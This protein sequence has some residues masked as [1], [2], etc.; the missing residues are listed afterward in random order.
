MPDVTG[1]FPLFFGRLREHQVNRGAYIEN[2]PGKQVSNVYLAKPSNIVSRSTDETAL[3]TSLPSY[4][5]TAHEG[6]TSGPSPRGVSSWSANQECTEPRLQ[7]NSPITLSLSREYSPQRNRSSTWHNVDSPR[8]SRPP[9]PTSEIP[10]F[11]P[12]SA[13]RSSPNSVPRPSRG[14]TVVSIN[15]IV[16]QAGNSPC[17]QHEV[18]VVT[19]A[20]ARWHPGNVSKQFAM[21]NKLCYQCIKSFVP[22]PIG[23]DPRVNKR[24]S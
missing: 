2:R 12:S 20:R 9:R 16:G 13:T 4:S 24:P 18:F 11:D 3:Q 21:T 1:S 5:K 19:S 22:K 23:A 14:F 10:P 17:Q 8:S 6:T 7:L 15:G